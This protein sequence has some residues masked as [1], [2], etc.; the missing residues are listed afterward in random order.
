MGFFHIKKKQG[1]NTHIPEDMDN[2]SKNWKTLSGETNW[3]GLFD[4]PGQYLRNYIIHYGEMAQATY[5]AFNSVKVSKYAGSSRY[6]I[7]NLLSRVGISQ[8]RPLN[9]YHVI[10]YLYATSSIALPNAFIVKSLSRE[11]WSKE[12]NWMGFVVVATDEGKVTL[13][14]RDILIT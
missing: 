13:G 6:A 7:T 5:D 2:I 14:R 10:K 8:G 3:K 1:K 9:K 4:P 12:S 11:T